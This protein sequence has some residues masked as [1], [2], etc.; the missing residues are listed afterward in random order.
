M[1]DLTAQKVRHTSG[2]PISW[3]AGTLDISR[4]DR[5]TQGI[6]EG[7]HALE[8]VV[9]CGAVAAPILPSTNDSFIVAVDTDMLGC[10]GLMKESMDKEFKGNH[11]KPSDI[12]NRMP[13]REQMPSMPAAYNDDGNTHS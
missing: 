11:F 1:E 6:Q 12:P 4:M 7:V 2:R 10:I 5:C 8:D 13:T 3:I 9:D